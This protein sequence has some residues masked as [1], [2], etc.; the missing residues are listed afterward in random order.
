MSLKTTLSQALKLLTP[1]E[2]H[3]ARRILALIVLTGLIDT[4]GLTPVLPLLAVLANPEV[5]ISNRYIHAAY[6]ALGFTDTRDFMVFLGTSVLLVIVA[7]N[8]LNAW[9][10][11]RCLA[12]SLNV[13]HQLSARM[14]NAY[15]S[16]PYVFFLNENSS[17]IMVDVVGRVY[18]L[19]HGVLSPALQVISKVVLAAFIFA[20]L[21]TVNP[22][23]SLAVGALV[24]GGYTCAY[25]LLRERLK[26]YGS[27]ANLANEKRGK[28]GHEAFHGI[29]EIKATGRESFFAE[30]YMQA[31][32]RYTEAYIDNGFVAIV[33]RYVLEVLAIGGMVGAILFLLLR[34]ASL[35]GILPVLGLYALAAYRLLPAI[36]QIFQGAALIRFSASSVATLHD[37]AMRLNSRQTIDLSQHAA[38]AEPLPFNKAFTFSAV[39]F[40]YPNTSTAVLKKIDFSIPKN[41]S[42]GVV[43]ATGAGKTTVIDL[44]M[45]LL[46]PAAGKVLVDDQDVF[47]GNERRWRAGIGYVPQSIYLADTTIASNIAFGVDQNMIDAVRLESAAKLARIHEFIET[48]LPQR[49]QT[50]VGERGVRLSGGQ[51]QRIGIAR[52]LYHQPALL[53]F[54]EATSALDNQTEAA[55]VDAIQSLSHSVTMLIVA[56]RLSTVRAC[57]AILML[58]RG[59]IVDRG[60]YD[61]LYA[62]NPAFRA[63]A[64][65]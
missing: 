36:Q 2:K 7:T 26:Q 8:M 22:A 16:Q 29:K 62:R 11:R 33:P 39:E 42:L 55:I 48:E 64:D 44:A 12:F 63:L 43:G 5:A 35:T 20:L 58:E 14:L 27:E 51:R 59:E 19:V 41:S 6:L 60:S 54:D 15:L 30:R 61:E 13:G 40:S 24:G 45:A 56:H 65:R 10:A 18:D 46:E 21:L 4:V 38:R 50:V 1:A 52:A 9:T 23:L 17:K 57:D 53:I 32:K 3:E 49:Y 25:L 28:F 37:T 47:D 34:G 31:S